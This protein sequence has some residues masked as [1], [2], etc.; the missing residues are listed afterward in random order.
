MIISKKDIINIILLFIEPKV[1]N[2]QEYMVIIHLKNSFYMINLKYIVRII[3]LDLVLLNLLQ[4]LFQDMEVMFLLID[5]NII[6]IILKILISILT[7]PI[8]Y[9]IIWSGYQITKDMFQRVLLILREIKDLIAFQ[10]KVK[11]FHKF[12][13]IDKN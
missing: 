3:K 7:K 4:L 5:L 9:L 2:I 1:L 11:I 13:Y 6:W 8:I 10:P 12:N